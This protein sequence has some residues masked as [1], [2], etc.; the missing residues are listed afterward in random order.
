MTE[1]DFVGGIDLG[2]TKVLSLCLDSQ[3]EI[4]GQ[5]QRPTGAERGLDAVLDTMAASLTQARGE[6]RLTAIGISTPGPSQPRLGIVTSPPNLPGWRDVPLTALMS[7][8]LGL[9]CWIENVANAAGV[10]EHRLGA[11]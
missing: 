8:K 7:Q 11:G 6:H 9:P 3:L 4:V 10:A 2:G 1:H 5:D